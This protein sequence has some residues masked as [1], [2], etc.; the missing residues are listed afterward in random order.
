MDEYIERL[1]KIERELY[2]IIDGSVWAKS[3]YYVYAEVGHLL[4]T[5]RRK[6]DEGKTGLTYNKGIHQGESTK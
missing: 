3:T 5:M 2:K 4:R 1:E 6:R